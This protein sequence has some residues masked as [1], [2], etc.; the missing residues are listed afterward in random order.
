MQT[1][2][3]EIL[4]A[5]LASALETSAFIGIEPM[6]DGSVPPAGADL[7][8]L[9]FSGVFQGDLQIAA[10]RALGVLLA[11]NVLAL[12]QESAEALAAAED[13]AKELCNITAGV[14]LERLCEPEQM[15]QMGLPVLGRLADGE[16]WQRFI[17][18]PGASSACADGHPIAIR[19]VPE[20]A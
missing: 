3:P 13:A 7:V 20:G 12:E 11:A 14:L 1:P 18:Q 8:S 16:A 10:P 15:P 4:L 5:S 6:P 9:R 19:L 17:S 2:D